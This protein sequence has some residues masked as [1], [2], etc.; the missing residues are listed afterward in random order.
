ME[1]ISLDNRGLSPPEP[2]VRVLRALGGL[3]E[4]Q[5][6]VVLMDREPLILYR[7]LERRGLEWEFDTSRGI[8][9]IRRPQGAG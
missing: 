8:L 1:P 2:M 6:M 7:E 4:G 3:S 9:T 5:E